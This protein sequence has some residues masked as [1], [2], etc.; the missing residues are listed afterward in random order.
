M[1]VKATARARRA[2]LAASLGVIDE[3]EWP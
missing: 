2:R 1:A 3:G